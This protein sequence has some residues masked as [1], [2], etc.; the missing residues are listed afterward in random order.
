MALAYTVSTFPIILLISLLFTNP[1][2]SS[3]FVALLNLFM[4]FYGF[5]FTWHDESPSFWAFFIPQYHYINFLIRYY[6]DHSASS[7]S[8]HEKPL[9]FLVTHSKTCLLILFF[10]YGLVYIFI[11]LLTHQLGANFRK[12]FRKCFDSVKRCFSRRQLSDRIRTISDKIDLSYEEPKT[13]LKWNSPEAFDSETDNLAAFE[14]VKPDFLV[15]RNVYK[16]FSSFAALSN[17]NVALRKGEITCL[18]GH[19]GAGKS[20]LINILTGIMRP[21]RGSIFWNDRVYFSDSKPENTLNQVGIGICPASDVLSEMMTVYEHLKLVAFVK[22]IPNKE[23]EIRKVLELMDLTEHRDK[24]IKKVSGGCR[25]K[26]SLAI[27]LLGD[28]QIIFLDEPTSS[29]DPISR[30][31]VLRILAKLKV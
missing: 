7:G 27:A 1:K 5:S 12:A 22:A 17:V 10:L 26:L 29:L 23:R 19:N 20:T 6:L 21:S 13:T 18:L 28:P 9:P 3:G 31:E 16:Y 25:R 4:L 8:I 24:L 15:L 14:K 2:V 30:S 11:E